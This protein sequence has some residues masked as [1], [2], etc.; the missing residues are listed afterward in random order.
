MESKETN[1]FKQ[2]AKYEPYRILR[3]GVWNI[4][5]II[6]I[7]AFFYIVEIAKNYYPKEKILNEGK[8]YFWANIIFGEVT[9][10]VFNLGMMVIYKMKHQFFEQYKTDKEDWPWDA[11]PKAWKNLLKETF[12]V[13]F[14]NQ[15][16]LIPLITVP[17]LITGES[18]VSVQ[19]DELPSL[20]TII[21]HLL[22]FLICE[23]FSF[24]CTHR[25]L[26]T[27]YLYSKIHKLH[28][29]YRH[30]VGIASEFAHPIEFVFGNILTTYSG[31]LILGR[32]THFFTDCVWTFIRIAETTDGHCGYNF[33]WSPYRLLP[34][35]AGEDYHNYHHQEFEGN[36][37]S[38]STIWDRLFGTVNKQFLKFVDSNY[39]LKYG[40]AIKSK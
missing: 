28:H 21:L 37:G 27:K 11:D 25:L 32:R 3:R 1:V 22:F 29:K 7:V 26:H 9:F 30:T 33:P 36:Y 14:V 34:L 10:I 8:F 5:S 19:Y 20:Q 18:P 16:I 31:V 40:K 39:E 35:S 13:L 12:L 23:D 6:I 24:Y 38:F 4:V 15:F 2:I 17:H